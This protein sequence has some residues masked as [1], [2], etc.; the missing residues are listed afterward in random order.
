VKLRADSEAESLILRII[1]ER[2][3]LPILSEEKGRIAGATSGRASAG[4]SIRSTAA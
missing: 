4:S 1:R 2:S 3:T